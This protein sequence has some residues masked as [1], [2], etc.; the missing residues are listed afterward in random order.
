VTDADEIEWGTMSA[1][2][3]CTIHR[4]ENDDVFVIVAGVKIAKRGVRGTTGAD[5]WIML[6][7]GW[8][9]RDAEGGKAVEV[10]Y[11]HVEWKH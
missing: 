2:N 10:R 8:L 5:T 4:D 7:P 3:L 6:Q 1:E 9:V 11:E